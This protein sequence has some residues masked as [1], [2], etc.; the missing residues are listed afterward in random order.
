MGEYVTANNY[1]VLT[2][3]QVLFQKCSAWIKSFSLSNCKD[4]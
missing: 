4:T 3:Y 1:R 2:T